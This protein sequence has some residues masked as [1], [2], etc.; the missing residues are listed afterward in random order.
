MNNEFKDR[1]SLFTGAGFG[2]GRAIAIALAKAGAR[3]VVADV[4]LSGAEETVATI[5]DGTMAVA[6]DISD[7]GSVEKLTQRA[8]G[9]A[10]S[11]PAHYVH[12]PWYVRSIAHLLRL[13]V[14]HKACSTCLASFDLGPNICT[15]TRP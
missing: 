7:K 10:R 4:N 3:V 13:C 15:D 14:R 1:V 11:T 6:V 9:Q 8:L 5:G 12:G 2:I